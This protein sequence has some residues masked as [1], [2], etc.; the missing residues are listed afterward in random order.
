V[1]PTWAAWFILLFIVIA[2]FA[3]VVRTKR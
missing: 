2:I 3:E 1:I